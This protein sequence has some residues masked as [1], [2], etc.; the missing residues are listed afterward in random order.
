MKHIYTGRDHVS[1]VIALLLVVVIARKRAG[2]EQW[3]NRPFWPALRATAVVVTAFTIAH[4][5]TLIAASLGWFQLPSRFVESM[6]GASIA[7]TAVENIFKPDVR[8]RYGLTFGFG[9]IHGLGF[10]S[11]LAV[12]LPP[13]QV[14]APLLEFNIGV[15]LGQLS[16]VAVA[17]PLLAVIARLVGAD[18]YRNRVMPALSGVI[19]V[20][21]AIWVVERVFEV[22]LLGL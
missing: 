8:W 15:E 6:I 22:E 4:S 17:L 14:V 20:L 2:D 5:L 21:G 11:M 1:F 18:R 13:D 3:E 12:L 16:I 10:A 19:A 7:Y 9:L